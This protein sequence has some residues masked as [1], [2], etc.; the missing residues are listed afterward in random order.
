MKTD[1]N[2]S[3]VL[4]GDVLATLIGKGELGLV[5]ATVL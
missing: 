5:V 3:L 4:S 2:E 1:I